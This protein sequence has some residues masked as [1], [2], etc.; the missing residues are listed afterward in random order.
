MNKTILILEDDIGLSQ[1]MTFILEKK[2]YVVFVANTILEAD[3]LWKL[4]EYDL[5]VLD[6]SLPD[7][8]GL[9]FC[10]FIRAES[11][12]PIIFLTAADDEYEIVN[13]LDIGADDYITKPFKLAIF[14]SRLN[15]LLRRSEIAHENKDEIISNELKVNKLT[16]DVYK[17]DQKIE[18]TSLEYKLL[19]LFVT[20]KNVVLTL[21]III[22]NV[23]GCD[24]NYVDT[25][26]LTV[27]IRRLRLKIEDDPS[28]PKIIITIRGKGYKWFE[29]TK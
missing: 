18:L 8:S 17:S 1:G 6:V 10:Q 21:E 20:N 4:R 3:K 14:L 29:E 9:D 7:G 25:N 28:N 11:I 27:Y 13:G 26:T 24:E 2:G 16:R 23:W 15:A 19:Y 22:T 5:A 12:L